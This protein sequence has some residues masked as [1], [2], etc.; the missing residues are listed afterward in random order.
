MASGKIKSLYIK[1]EEFFKRMKSKC[2]DIPKEE[3]SRES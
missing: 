1:G 3:A 2:S